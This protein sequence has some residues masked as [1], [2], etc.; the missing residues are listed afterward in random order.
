MMYVRNDK[1][2]LEFI[3]KVLTVFP[4]FKYRNVANFL[5]QSNGMQFMEI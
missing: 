2:G 4:E 1:A 3:R 5:R